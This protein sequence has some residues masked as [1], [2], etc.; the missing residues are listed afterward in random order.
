MSQP[1]KRARLVKSYEDVAKEL[2][3]AD[4]SCCDG[5]STYSLLLIPTENGKGIFQ[6]KGVIV[7]S[8]DVSGVQFRDCPEGAQHSNVSESET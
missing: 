4:C 5:T 6:R 3:L 7:D 1:K 2:F 8:S